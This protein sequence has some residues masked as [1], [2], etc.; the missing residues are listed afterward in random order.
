MIQDKK[1]RLRCRRVEET[2]SFQMQ[3][4]M[5][6]VSKDVKYQSHFHEILLQTRF[7]KIIK[8]H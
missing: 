4:K 1:N 6:F 3:T 2:F 7:P 5:K 8:K